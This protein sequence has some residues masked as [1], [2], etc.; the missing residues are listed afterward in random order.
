MKALFHK[1]LMALPSPSCWRRKASSHG[2][3]GAAE[4]A[5]SCQNE[6]IS[7]PHLEETADE[8]KCRLS[9]VARGLV[10][11]SHAPGLETSPPGLA[12]Q[13]NP[14]PLDLAT[15]GLG[16]ARPGLGLRRLPRGTLRD[17]ASHLRCLSPA[18]ASP[19]HLPGGVLGR[20]GPLA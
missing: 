10:S 19:R 16:L 2:Q 6:G 18:R 17:G 5:V 1:R 9:F 7:K 11:V 15:L 14:F 20:P 3:T 4:K 12:P 8:Q 13:T